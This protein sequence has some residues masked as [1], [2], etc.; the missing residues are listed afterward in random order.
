MLPQLSGEN[1]IFV[2]GKPSPSV[3]LPQEREENQMQMKAQEYCV[4]YYECIVK[5]PEMHT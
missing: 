1:L 2:K 5:T 4:K 3:P